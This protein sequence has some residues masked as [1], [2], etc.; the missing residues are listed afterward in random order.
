MTNV[1]AELG[2]CFAN[3]AVAI[4][5]SG[6]PHR[7]ADQGAGRGPRALGHRFGMEWITAMAIEAM[8]RLEIPEGM[9][10]IRLP[11]AR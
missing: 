5:S 10:E 8:R 6:R 4:P 2:T 1:Y 9:Q 7:H 3:S 11:A